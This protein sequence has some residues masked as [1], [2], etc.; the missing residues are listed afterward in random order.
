[1]VARGRAIAL[2]AAAVVL[3]SLASP[4]LASAHLRSGTV[5]VDYKASVVMP[6]GGADTAQIFQSDRALSLTVRRGH[7]VTVLGYLGEPMLRLDGAG[8]SINAASPTAVAEKLVAKS[9]RVDST[10]PHWLLR[11]GRR[12]VTWQDA[13]V[14]GLPPGVSVGVWHVPLIVDGRHSALTGTLHRFPAPAL[15]PWLA[16]LACFLVGGA[17]VFVRR[18][19]VLRP[20]A[21]ALA[22]LAAAAS[23]IVAPAFALDAYASPGT[24]I[25]GVDELIFLAVGLYVLRR[26][27]RHLHVAAAV[28][29]GLLG[30]AIGISKVA[31]FLHPIVL[32]VLP[33]TVMRIVVIVAV[34]A[35]IAGGALGC[36]LYAGGASPSNGARPASR[37]SVDDSAAPVV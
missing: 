6:P 3:A 35:G 33:G 24:W 34:G 27:P 14:R 31:V 7:A 2:S 13:R 18:R 30:L 5:A 4:G 26:G 15:W 25:A 17:F 28:G 12:S 16:I 21:I 32:A 23:I 10:T 29:L 8:V 36:A 20:A 1:V 22:V 9:E 11:A 37:G 19:D